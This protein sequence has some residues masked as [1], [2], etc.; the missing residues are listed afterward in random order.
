MSAFDSRAHKVGAAARAPMVRARVIYW[1][2]RKMYVVSV[3]AQVCSHF[4]ACACT[5]SVVH[6]SNCIS[7][8][9]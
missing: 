7:E 4:H 6:N 5:T 1:D 8:E 2:G 3:L 9:L